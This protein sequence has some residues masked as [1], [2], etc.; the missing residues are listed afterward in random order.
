MPLQVIVCIL[1]SKFTLQSSTWPWALFAVKSQL[2]PNNFVS[3]PKVVVFEIG[4][5]SVDGLL[6]LCHAAS[7]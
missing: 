7:E 2:N 3:F 5:H 1:P 4:S 6:S